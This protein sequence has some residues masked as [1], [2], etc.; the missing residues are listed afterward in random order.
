MY[1]PRC[2]T[3]NNSDQN[4]CRGCG[5]DLAPISKVLTGR[6]TEQSGPLKEITNYSKLPMF[7]WGFLGLWIGLLLTIALG[8]GGDLLARVSKPVGG[9]LNE[10]TGL[11]VVVLLAGVG[12]MIYSCLYPARAASTA[13]RSVALNSVPTNALDEPPIAVSSPQQSI[14]EHTTFRLDHPD[15]ESP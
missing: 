11:A 13:D 14:A 3:E 6:S 4:F 15:S 5:M 9:L 1:C 7:R 8:V 10:M 2:A 12:L